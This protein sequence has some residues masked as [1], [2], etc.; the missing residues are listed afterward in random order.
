[1]AKNYANKLIDVKNVKVD[2][3]T[4]DKAL[5]EIMGKYWVAMFDMADTKL[6]FQR[7]LKNEMNA[8]E[9]RK[10]SSFIQYNEEQIEEQQKIVEKLKD[11]QK[12]ITD[13]INSRIKDCYRLISS[14]MYELYL[15]GKL[16][17]AVEEF[18]AAHNIKCDKSLK[19]YFSGLMGV[20]VASAKIMYNTQSFISKIGKSDFEKKYMCGLAELMKEKGILIVSKYEW[21]YDDEKSAKTAK[22]QQRKIEKL[23]NLHC[24]KEVELPI[25]KQENASSDRKASFASKHT[26]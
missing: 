14:S 3:Y 15:S 2:F 1:M 26:A 23:E 4:G 9:N 5:T 21:K 12:E 16:D 10:N 25:E 24:E 6:R 17:Q 7:E 20:K 19:A 13:A 22:P 18:F 8:L 11:Q